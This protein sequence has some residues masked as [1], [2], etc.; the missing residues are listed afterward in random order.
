MTL[1]GHL[2]TIKKNYQEIPRKKYQKHTFVYLSVLKEDY[3]IHLK[4]NDADILIRKSISWLA[5]E[6]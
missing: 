2:G 5:E 4:I 1:L 3:W 6:I